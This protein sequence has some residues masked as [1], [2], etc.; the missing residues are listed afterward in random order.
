MRKFWLSLLPLGI[1]AGPAF[2]QAIPGPVRFGGVVEDSTTGRPLAG[3]TVTLTRARRV[4]FTD[5]AGRFAIVLPRPV[6]DRVQVR[7]L[8]FATR[9]FEAVIGAGA[10]TLRVRMT[11]DPVPMKEITARARR[12]G[13]Y[14][15]EGTVI[16]SVTG[17]PVPHAVVWF[18]SSGGNAVTDTVG[19]YV[20]DHARV[21]FED[22]VV[23]V[24]GYERRVAYRRVTEPWQRLDFA[25]Q[26]DPIMLEG[27][28][29][30]NQRVLHTSI[31]TRA[32]AHNLSERDFARSGRRAVSDFLAWSQAYSPPGKV[33]CAYTGVLDM[34][35]FR[36]PNTSTTDTLKPMVEGGIR[37]DGGSI[38]SV[39]VNNAF[40]PGGQRGRL[41]V[42]PSDFFR[43][44]YVRSSR[45][46]GMSYVVVLTKSQLRN[47]FHRRPGGQPAL[48]TDSLERLLA[49]A[50][51]LR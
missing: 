41:Q 36:R 8:G 48:A 11:P 49:Q 4:A 50:D 45:C 24:L 32:F 37:A 2:G 51:T 38:D 13:R 47:A 5:S 26:P 1:A 18:R 30:L 39:I 40:L 42:S 25:L 29:V 12:N 7:Q 10:P 34:S 43:A 22:V 46:G 15:I 17:R 21:G 28:V 44:V 14:T 27:L 23:D 6:T 3:A 31:S 35:G 33:A 19:H 20:F 16:D 9:T